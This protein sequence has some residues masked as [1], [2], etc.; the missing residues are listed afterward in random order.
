M[1]SNIRILTLITPPAER[2][3]HK[4][5]KREDLPLPEPTETAYGSVDFSVPYCHIRTFTLGTVFVVVERAKTEMVSQPL[6]IASKAFAVQKR[7]KHVSGNDAR[8]RAIRTA[9]FEHA[10]S[11]RIH[12]GIDMVFKALATKIVL[13]REREGVVFAQIIETD[14]AVGRKAL[15]FALFQRWIDST[16]TCSTHKPEN[17]VP[18]CEEGI[19]QLFLLEVKVD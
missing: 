4:E 1:V 7:L 9:G 15:C 13:T 8:T 5:R 11:S 14:A 17:L 10:F 12:L 18:V 2:D 3:Q 16:L 19:F 6:L